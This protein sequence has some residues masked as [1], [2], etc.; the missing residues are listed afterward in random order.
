MGRHCAGKVPGK[1][2]GGTRRQ[3]RS[4]RVDEGKWDGRGRAKGALGLKSFDAFKTFW[5]LVLKD[6]LRCDEEDAHVP[7]ARCMN[8]SA[9]EVLFDVC[10]SPRDCAC[11]ERDLI[12][13]GQLS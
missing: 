1:R 12:E 13:R 7:D 4:R 5:N 10:V 9:V 6:D 3:S 8:L 2:H 11:A